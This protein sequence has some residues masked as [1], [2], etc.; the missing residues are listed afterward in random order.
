M[1]P[2]IAVYGSSL[3]GV[4]DPGYPMAY[5]LGAALARGGAT[6]VTGGY[7]GV[8]AAASRGAAEAGGH[9]IGVTVEPYADRGSGNRWVAERIHTVD[10]LERMREL[11]VTPDARVAVEPSLGTLNEVFLAWTLASQGAIKPGSLVLLGP[12]WPDYLEAHRDVVGGEL[13]THLR[14]ASTAAEAAQLALTAARRP[15]AKAFL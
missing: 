12:R 10:L 13:L 11:V 9:V 3:L 7:G 14:C 6:V 8:M 5:D 1:A 4:N 15:A 2:R